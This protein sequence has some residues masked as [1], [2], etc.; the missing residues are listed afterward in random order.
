MLDILDKKKL[1]KKKLLLIQVGKGKEKNNIDK[2]EITYPKKINYEN[3]LNRNF[4]FVMDNALSVRKFGNVA[5][6][7][8]IYFRAED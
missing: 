3:K 5:K 6:K 1:I 4:N 2:R 7:N 8:K